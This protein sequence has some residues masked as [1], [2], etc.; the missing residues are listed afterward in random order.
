MLVT[1][2]AGYLGS[3]VVRVARAQGLEV[4]GTWFLRS[5]EGGVRLDVRDEVAVRTILAEVR[6]DTVVHTAYVQGGDDLWPT[7]AEA[8]A[9][10]AAATADRGVRLVH[11]S[12]DLVFDGDKDGRYTE[13]DEPRPVMPYGEAKAAAERAVL[14]ADPSA[15]VARASLIYGG[16][17]HQE[18]LVRRGEIAFF[19]DELR[20]P[21][22]VGDLAA[23]LVELAVA[24]DHAGV[25]HLGGT[26]TVSRFELASLIAGPER[27]SKLRTARST[28]FPGRRPRNC[29][30]DSSLAASLLT[31][32]L[33]GVREVLSAR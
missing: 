20:T 12:S 28:D 32:G 21:V 25:V 18:E 27:A 24:T 14:S 3:E 9:V 7:T 17:G 8:P 19:T 1:G 33:R 10:L 30:L 11:V 23:A 4:V 16:A 5:V 22:E 15:V 13:A 2:S 6:P 26:D 31:T 29:A